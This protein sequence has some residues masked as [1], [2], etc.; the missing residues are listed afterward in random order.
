MSKKMTGKKKQVRQAFLLTKTR[1]VVTIVVA[2]IAAA[3]ACFVVWYITFARTHLPPNIVIN[4][5]N[6]GWQSYADAQKILDEQLGSPPAHTVQFIADDISIASSSSELGAHYAI[7]ETLNHFR[8]AS[9][10]SSLQARLQW[11]LTQLFTETKTTVSLQYDLA[12]LQNTLSLLNKQVAYPAIYPEATLA[13]TGNPESL[14]IIAGERGREVEVDTTLNTLSGAELAELMQVEASMASTGAQLNETEQLAARERAAHYVG[15]QIVLS[16][17]RRT[18]TLSDQELLPL[19]QFPS[20]Y[21]LEKIEERVTAWQE[22]LSRPAQEPVFTYDPESLEVSE[23]I[24]PHDGLQLKVADATDLL[25]A[26][27]DLLAEAAEMAANSEADSET[28]ETPAPE[29]SELAEQAKQEIALPL[30]RTK[31]TKSLADTNDLGIT[32]SIGFGESH[33]KGSI[34]NRVHNVDLSTNRISGQIIPPGVEYS[35]NQALGPVSS[36]TGYRSAYVIKNGMTTLGDGG[37]VCQTSTTLFR[38]ILDAGLEVTRRLPHSYRVSYYEQ[39]QK[40]GIDATVYSGETDLRFKNDTD[41]HIL[42][43]GEADSQNLYMFFEMY[44][45]SD[46]RTTEIVD[47]RTWNARPAPP[48]QYIPDPS[49]EPGQLRQVD[50]AAAG[51]QASFTNVIRDAEGNEI[52]RDT[53]N[54]NYRPWAAKFLRGE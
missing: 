24:P 1:L 38:V 52:R 48:P 51:I 54:S 18:F 11:L 39:D 42:L 20:G 6:L 2:T 30:E 43:Y 16:G 9:L 35:F 46:G 37:G 25:I 3:I 31:P 49:L 21:N 50:W 14:S 28:T 4:E 29:T 19:L 22:S 13:N 36:S 12:Q 41:H 23:F 26:R 32:E 17:G 47:H 7:E 40:P 33:Y 44:G 27:L 10:E 53:Y 34:P 5:V 45:T 8:A 15:Q